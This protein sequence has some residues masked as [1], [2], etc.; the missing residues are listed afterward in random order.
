MKAT[1]IILLITNLSLNT[2][3]AQEYVFRAKVDLN[4]DNQLETIK[5]EN[6]DKPYEYKLTINDKE[7][8][9]SFDAEYSDGFKV[10]DIDVDDK[11]KEI[12]VHTQGP[13]DDISN[14]VYWYNGKEVLLIEQLH[15]TVI[16]NGNGIIYLDNWEGFWTS[17]DK[18][19]LEKITQDLHL[20]QQFAYYVGVKAKVKKGFTIYKETDLIN[21]V[22]SLSEGSEIELLL[23]DKTKRE[24]FDRRFLIKSASGLTGWSDL[25]TIQENTEGLTWA[26]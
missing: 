10:I 14:I 20:T 11:Y 26:D 21:K 23:C 18:Y 13:S 8:T 3:Y 6:T 5:L 12:A 24:F 9:G 7:V 22:A 19:V 25:K 4:S 17:R 16:I 2:T 15:G 1:I